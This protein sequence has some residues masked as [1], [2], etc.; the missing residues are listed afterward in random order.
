ME[1]KLVVG[2]GNPGGRYAGTRHNVGY[3]V[4]DALA[5]RLGMVRSVDEFN[6]LART[7]F[8]GLFLDCAAGSG[9]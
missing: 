2:L 5:I 8:D 4:V 7:K 1:R 6:R 3:E 9:E